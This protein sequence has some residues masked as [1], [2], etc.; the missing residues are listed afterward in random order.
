M[1]KH[2]VWSISWSVDRRCI[3][4]IIVRF[5]VR[6]QYGASGSQGR[7]QIVFRSQ[8]YRRRACRFMAVRCQRRGLIS[9][10]EAL[11]SRVRPVGISARDLVNRVAVRCQR[12]SVSQAYQQ[13]QSAGRLK[14]YQPSWHGIELTTVSMFRRLFSRGAPTRERS[15]EWLT[16]S[17]L[18]SSH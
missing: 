9:G 2:L 4:T 17:N 6:W 18:L 12:Q 8:G 7:L 3:S 11:P 15:R 1:V 10:S 5:K 13:N 16:K 14:L